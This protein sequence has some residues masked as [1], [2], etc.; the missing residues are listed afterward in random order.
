REVWTER[1]SVHGAKRRVSCLQE[2]FRRF[3][4]GRTQLADREADVVLS[5]YQEV[6]GD[7]GK[8][9]ECGQCYGLMICPEYADIGKSGDLLYRAD[10]LGWTGMVYRES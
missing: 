6:V 3:S 7:V 1:T 5:L 9:L 10:N 2:L 8:L 4:H